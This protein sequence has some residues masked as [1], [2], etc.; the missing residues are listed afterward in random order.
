MSVCMTQVKLEVNKSSYLQLKSKAPLYGCIT[1]SV[2]SRLWSGSDHHSDPSSAQGYLIQKLKQDYGSCLS[3]T[4]DFVLKAALHGRTPSICKML[5]KL[6]L[7]FHMKEKGASVYV[8]K[9]H[10]SKGQFWSFKL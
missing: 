8:N 2:R 4:E 3:I 6:I 5:S 1:T 9:K 10:G 7:L